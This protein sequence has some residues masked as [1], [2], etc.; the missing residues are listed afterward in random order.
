MINCKGIDITVAYDMKVYPCIA[1]HVYY[2]LFDWD[3][4][5]SGLHPDWNSLEYNSMEDILRTYEEYI[6][7][8]N[9]ADEKKCPPHC[10]RSC[11]V[12]KNL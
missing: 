10:N 1:Y 9:W 5:F 11:R 12:Y 7:E 8:K 3:G 6:N 2:E 4:E